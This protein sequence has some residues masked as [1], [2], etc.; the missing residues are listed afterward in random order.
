MREYVKPDLMICGHLHICQICEPGG[1]L[2]DLGQPCTLVV[3]ADPDRNNV[4][5][6]CGFTFCDEGITV[7]FTDSDNKT[8]EKF[9]IK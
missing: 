3:G 2:D 8:Q 9:F 7:E 1:L 4:Y 5:K 6:A